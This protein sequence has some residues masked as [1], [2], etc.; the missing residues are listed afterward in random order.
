ME[1][2]RPPFLTGIPVVFPNSSWEYR[3]KFFIKSR[4][5]FSCF[6][7][8]DD[9][10]LSPLDFIQSDFAI[11]FVSPLRSISFPRRIRWVCLSVPIIQEFIWSRIIGLAMLFVRNVVLSSAIGRLFL[12]PNE[13][14]LLFQ[15]CGSWNWMAL[16]QQW[17]S[18][19]K[20]PEP[21]WSP[22]NVFRRIWFVYYYFR[23]AWR[24][25]IRP[26]FGQCTTK[27]H[28]QRG[29]TDDSSYQC[30]SRDVRAPPST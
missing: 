11:H 19:W 16:V 20:R 8:C 6:L 24:I 9:F 2:N 30:Y 1:V 27:D 13:T 4:P 12:I 22:W 17:E 15:A 21:C 14:L 26:V 29:S 18:I 5:Q 3:P 23:W 28:E 25:W 7:S 10:L